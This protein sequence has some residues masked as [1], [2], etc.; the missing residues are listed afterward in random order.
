MKK[1]GPAEIWTQIKVQG[2]NHYTAKP[3]TTTFV[4]NIQNN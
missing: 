4:L 3:V 2:A 1:W